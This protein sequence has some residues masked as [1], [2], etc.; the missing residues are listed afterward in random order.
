MSRRA[1]DY[2][3]ALPPDRIAQEP[4]A[5]RDQARL[6]VVR[7][8]T[9]QLEHRVFADLPDLLMESDLLVM[10][11][12][13]VIP[14]RIH[15]RK[16]K[17]GGKVELLF[18]DE[19]QP[20]I[21]DVLLRASRRPAIGDELLLPDGHTMAT[22][23]ADGEQGRAQVRVLSAR[24]AL[25]L[26]DQFGATPLPPYIQRTGDDPRR[27]ADPER[28]QTIYARTPGAVAAPTAGLHFTPELLDR[29]QRKHMNPVFLTL[30][31]GLGTFRPV[32]VE[33]VA[34]H[35]MEEERYDIPADTAARIRAARPDGRRIIAVGTTTVRTLESA[36]Q[37]D[38][39]LPGG[40]GRTRLFIHHPYTFRVVDAL[41]TNFH[42]PRSTLFMLVCAFA[43]RE[44]M[45][46]VYGEAIRRQYR[47]YSYGDAM[48]IV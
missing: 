17:T 24:P 14:A 30:H 18:L 44:F 2:D 32:S 42:L 37:P 12:T 34:Q 19:P 5:R 43:G 46:E 40:P 36:V 45:L 35:L 29:L 13:R 11:N 33:D 28:Y 23:I 41:I 26:L 48:L 25:Q 22:L 8:Q 31:V 39:V 20:G 9:R 16:R 38:G 7:R 21:W 1:A 3:F 15:A 27:V 6:L 10:N 47:F 4:A